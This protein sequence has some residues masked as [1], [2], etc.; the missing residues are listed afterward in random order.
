MPIA[1]LCLNP[2]IE[3]EQANGTLIAAAPEL[4][5]ALEQCRDTIQRLAKESP[6]GVPMWASEAHDM[7][8]AAIAKARGEGK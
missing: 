2:G 6:Y 4:L 1:M 8:R 3:Q 5:A 7:A